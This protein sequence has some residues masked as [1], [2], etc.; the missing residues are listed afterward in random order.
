MAVLQTAESQECSK[1][2]S[3]LL[4]PSTA[5][6][7]PEPMICIVPPNIDVLPQ[8]TYRWEWDEIAPDGSVERLLPNT[9]DTVCEYSICMRE[10]ERERDYEI[11]FHFR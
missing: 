7:D 1:P 5:A 10:R 9:S 11:N 6:T 8:D 3:N 2:A 4:T